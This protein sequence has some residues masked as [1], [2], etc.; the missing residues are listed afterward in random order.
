MPLLPQGAISTRYLKI[1]FIEYNVT[2]GSQV[3][4]WYANLF[5]NLDVTME[6]IFR[7]TTLKKMLG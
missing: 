7:F 4:I 5:V 3:S 6:F 1:T 2:Q